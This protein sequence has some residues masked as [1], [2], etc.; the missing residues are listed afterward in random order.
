MN[1]A[2]RELTLVIKALERSTAALGLRQG[3]LVSLVLWQEHVEEIRGAIRVAVREPISQNDYAAKVE[4]NRAAW[5]PVEELAGVLAGNHEDWGDEDF[6]ENDEGDK[7]ITD[8]AWDRV[9]DEK[10]GWLRERVADGT[11]QARGR[12]KQLKVQEGAFDDLV[13][14]RSGACPDDAHLLYQVIPDGEAE[15][16]ET[17][18]ALLKRLQRVLNWEPF[19]G[20]EGEAEPPAMPGKLIEALKGSTSHEL[21]STWVQLL[22]AEQALGEI[23]AEF[24]GTDPLKPEIRELL[25]ATKQSLL[26]HKEQLALLHMEVVLREPLAE[27]LDEMREFVR[28]VTVT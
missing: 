3:W 27:E 16:V 13:G 2:H 25:D 12:G 15:R 11:L 24:G 8:E 10:E 21:I 1:A 26:E 22:T 19:Y 5:V 7:E 18:R 6:A 14:R 20:A 28:T 23:A 9:C 17:D 4:A